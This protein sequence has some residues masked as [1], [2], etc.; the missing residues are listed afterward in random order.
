MYGGQKEKVLSFHN[1]SLSLAIGLS[2]E[3]VNSYLSNKELF[4]FSTGHCQTSMLSSWDLIHHNASDSPE[5]ANKYHMKTG[6]K[7]I[8]YIWADT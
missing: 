5:V 6:A 4:V 2:R 1:I 8:T 7:N 3:W